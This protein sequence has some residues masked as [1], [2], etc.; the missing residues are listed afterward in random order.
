QRR[1]ATF[2]LAARRAC[3][4]H[5][6]RAGAASLASLTVTS[7]RSSSDAVAG[8]SQCGSGVGTGRGGSAGD[9]THARG[10]GSGRN[11]TTAT[12]AGTTN[13]ST[14][15]ATARIKTLPWVDEVRFY[16][17][18]AGAATTRFGGLRRAA[19]GPER[20]RGRRRSS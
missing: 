18:P 3:V 13:N 15:S 6:T 20:G 7:R 11:T 8:T 5:A 16:G 2:G 9:F 14:P 19:P 17:A 12:R 1:K 4:S 10:S